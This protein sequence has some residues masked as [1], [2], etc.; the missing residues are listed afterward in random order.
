M[1]KKSKRKKRWKK[2]KEWLWAI[3]LLCLVMWLMFFPFVLVFYSIF[4]EDISLIIVSFINLA[5]FG[6]MIKI[7][8]DG[9]LSG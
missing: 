8:E 6:I 3:F 5:M 9:V 4:K 2:F 7:V 1:A